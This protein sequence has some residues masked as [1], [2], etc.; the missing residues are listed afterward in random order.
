[1]AILEALSSAECPVY[2]SKQAGIYDFIVRDGYSLNT[3]EPTIENISRVIK[4]ILN[5][6]N[7]KQIIK[8]QKKFTD[9]YTWDRIIE[10]YIKLYIITVYKH[11]T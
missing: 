2:L 8:Q 5:K 1:M 7:D 6:N 10:Q 9:K 3:F 4:D 11:E